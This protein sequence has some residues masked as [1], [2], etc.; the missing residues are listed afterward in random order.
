MGI[1]F[2]VGVGFKMLPAVNFNDQ[3]RFETYEI[4][5]IVVEGLLPPKSVAFELPTSQ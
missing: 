5:D 1:A 4:D 3:P 2:L